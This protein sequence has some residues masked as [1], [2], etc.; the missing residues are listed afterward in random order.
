MRLLVKGSLT[1]ASVCTFRDMVFPINLIFRP[2]NLFW[3][4]KG[5][6]TALKPFDWPLSIFSGRRN[7]D[8]ELSIEYSNE[9]YCGNT[10]NSGSVNQPSSDILVNGCSMLCGGNVSE[11]CGGPDRLDMYKINGSLPASTSTSTPGTDPTPMAGAPSVVPSAGGYGYI[12]CYTDS[13]AN[14]ALTGSTNP[15]SGTTLTVEL[16]A[17]ACFGF[18][19]FGVEYSDVRVL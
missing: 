5:P 7:A 10:I 3:E 13:T 9:C 18:T 8:S 14:R 15:V 17:A 4:R 2:V 16:C 11:Y 1:L 19:Y 12:G 6:S